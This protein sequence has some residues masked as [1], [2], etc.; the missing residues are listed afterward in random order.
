MPEKVWFVEDPSKPANR[1]LFRELTRNNTVI[2]ILVD[3]NTREHCLPLLP[4]E[5]IK[6]TRV[7]L[8]QI[9]SGED[10]KTLLS[11][12][13]LWET[14]TSR[15][16]D[17]RSVMI[18]L[19]GGVI[20]DLGGFVASVYKRG[21]DFY[22]VPTTLLAMVDASLGGKT[23]VDFMDF[24]NE[25]G[26]FSSPRGVVVQ[27]V[28]LKTLGKEQ[29][30]S[31]LAEIVKIALVSDATLWELIT[32]Q[33]PEISWY[34]PGII[35]RAITLKQQIVE[36]DYLDQGVRRILNFGHTVGHALET[37]YLNQGSPLLHGD[38]VA[39]GMICSTILSEHILQLNTDISR[40]IQSFIIKTF[41]PVLYKIEDIPLLIGYIRHDKKNKGKSNNFS[42]IKD[43]G[44]SVPNTEVKADQ[45]EEVLQLYQEMTQPD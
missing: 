38:A 40:I 23:G 44:M 45:L 6:D 36:K 3:E 42:L 20:C 1:S 14:L 25:L 13:R 43:I 11:C 27:P 35:R 32:Q 30:R 8:L 29:L 21:I 7:Q 22:H 4:E 39:A 2:F 18:H 10:Y 26:L 16:A 19:G 41:P 9:P 31:G 5:F 12:I 34:D 15:N 33:A 24:K 17:R 37:L 28:F